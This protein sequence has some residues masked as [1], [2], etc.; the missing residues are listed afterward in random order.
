M[1]GNKGYGTTL[2]GAT[3]GTVGSIMNITGPTEAADDIEVTSMDSTNSRKEFI[4]GLV[5]SGELTF[6]LI[7]VA[8]E[9]N[10]DQ[11]DIGTAQVWT[12]TMSDA[13]NTTIVGTGYIKANSLAIPYDDKVVQNVTIKYTGDIAVTP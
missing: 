6:D 5:D 1:A 11:T 8:A 3:T 13:G 4:P 12:I 7:Y 9:Y 2:A 10:Q